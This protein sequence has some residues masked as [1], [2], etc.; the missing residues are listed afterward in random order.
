MNKRFP[1]M[2]LMYSSLILS[3]LQFVIDSLGQNY[4]IYHQDYEK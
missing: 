3:H 2:E 4:K 1:A